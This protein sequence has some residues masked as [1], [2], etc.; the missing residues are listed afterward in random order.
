MWL[1]LIAGLLLVLAAA[2]AG[3]GAIWFLRIYNSAPAISDLKPRKQS[4][5]TKV[6]A[7]DGT[8]LG[9]I[10][11]ETIREPV[12]GD[13]MSH[14]V[15]DGTIA[16]EDKNFYKEGGID[17][18]AI[19]RAGWRDA[20][21]GGKPLQGASTITQQLVRNLY[22]TNPSETIRRKIVEA[23]LANEENDA[24]SKDT[25]LTEYLNTAPYGTNAGATALG[26]QA[27]AETYFS[28]PA[29][30]LTLPEAALIAGL[31]QAP[32]EY[33]PLLHPKAALTRR[34]DVLKAMLKQHYISATQYTSAVTH[35][36]ALHPSKRYTQIKQPYIFDFVQKELIQRYG[37]NVVRTGG[38]KVYTTINPRL[39]KAA[40]SAVDA[41]AVCSPNGGPASALASVDPKTGEIVALASSQHYSGE[42]QFNFAAQAHRQPGSSFKPFVL[43]TAIKQGVDPSSTFYDGSAPL[44]LTLPGGSSWTVNNSEPGSGTMSLV[45]ATVDS[46]NAVF[47]QLVLDVGV[48]QFADTAYSMGITS[49]LGVTAKGHACKRGPNCYIPPAAAIGGLSEGVTPLEMASAYATLAD[50]GVRRTP[51]MIAKVVFPDGHVERPASASGHRVLT[52]GEAYEVTKVLEGVI[53][54]GTGAGYTSIGCSSE[55]GKTG[56]TDGLSDAWFVGYTPLY[57]TAVWTGHPLSRSYTGFG[58]P[59][60]GPIWRSYMKAAQGRDCPDFKVPAELPSLTALHSTR[61]GARP[62]PTPSPG[63]TTSPTPQGATA[64]PS[65]TAG[66][67]PTATPTPG[68]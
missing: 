16:I 40:Q 19:V 45:D 9:V 7:A 44:T 29:K 31:P 52:E 33:N 4:L 65:P 1:V 24:N 66:A 21:A 42:S 68:K 53:T 22:I 67:S 43:A 41:C 47:A 11:S 58:G 14:W 5:V 30:R 28:R 38:L 27:A 56:T 25:I 34:N 54:K 36:L 26:V 50:G 12:A 23:H 17:V 46:V 60:S 6:Y 3:A 13:L 62:T 61:T 10:H 48:Q 32:S 59:T 15:K 63:T 18:Q 51:T 64:G 20:K 35:K 55:A 8:Q 49:R 37:A 57:S 39:Q 2:A